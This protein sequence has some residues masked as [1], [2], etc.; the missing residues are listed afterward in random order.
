M[1]PDFRGNKREE[2]AERYGPE[3]GPKVSKKFSEL[4]DED[5]T[6]QREALEKA[7]RACHLYA[8]ELRG[9]SVNLASSAKECEKARDMNKACSKNKELTGSDMAKTYSS[10]R[11]RAWRGSRRSSCRRCRRGR[12]APGR[13]LVRIWSRPRRGRRSRMVSEK[14]LRSSTRKW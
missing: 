12:S 7:I 8:Y 9:D 11:S 5:I 14:Q 10:S 2:K 3:D 13:R 4:T 6:R 1:G